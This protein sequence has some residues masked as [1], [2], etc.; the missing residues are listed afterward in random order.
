[1][2]I[3]AS[4]GGEQFGL[5]LQSPICPVPSQVMR[6]RAGPRQLGDEVMRRRRAHPLY[7][8]VVDVEEDLLTAHERHLQRGDWPGKQ[9]RRELETLQKSL[10]SRYQKGRARGHHCS[11]AMRTDDVGGDEAVQCVDVD[12]RSSGT[13]GQVDCQVIVGLAEGVDGDIGE[14]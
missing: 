9:R 1:M 5:L 3:P 7:L 8:V 10:V 2:W 11:M 12:P 13:G 14:R 6:V 4:D